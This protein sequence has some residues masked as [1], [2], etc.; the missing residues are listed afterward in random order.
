[1][2]EERRW[3]ETYKSKH[4]DGVSLRIDFLFDAEKLEGCVLAACVAI[5]LPLIFSRRHSS[6]TS[7]CRGITL[8][9]TV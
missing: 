2:R 9:G 4:D 5:L 3:I 1:M 7:S 8:Q 6:I